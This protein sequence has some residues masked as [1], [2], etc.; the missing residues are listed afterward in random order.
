MNIHDKPFF[1][2]CHTKHVGV[3]S[4]FVAL[5]GMNS[6]GA[7]YIVEALYKGARTIVTDKSLVLPSKIAH[8]IERVHAQLIQVPN[9]RKALAEFAARAYDYPAKKLKIIGI[10]GTKGKTSC[11]WLAE[12]IL[13][14]AGLRTAL[15]ST[16][17]NRIDDAL[18]PAQ[19]TTEHADY[20][21]AFLY[22]CVKQ[23]IDVVVMEVAAQALTLSRVHGILFDGII[24]TN[25]SQEH[26]E[27]Y[28]TISD[29][30]LAKKCI[31][32]HAQ[33]TACVCINVD[34]V[35]SRSIN[36][37]SAIQISV[38]NIKCPIRVD[39]VYTNN[40]FGG[41]LFNVRYFD[42]EVSIECPHL[43]GEY[44][45]SNIVLV[46]SLL[47]SM[48]ISWKDIQN[49]I[50]SFQGIP[51][52]IERVPL[53]NGALGVCDYAHNPSSLYAVLSSLRMQ[54]PHLLVIVGAGGMRDKNKRAV[55]GK[56]IA[57]FAEEIFLTAD[58]PRFE[59]VHTIIDDLLC[60]I[61]P[62]MRYKVTIEVD[63][64]RA[65]QKACSRSSSNSIIGLFGKGP[66]QYQII[67]DQKI[68]FN[69]IDILKKSL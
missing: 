18:F 55:M 58:N 41:L 50:H 30:F 26:G 14:T 19:L 67:G 25:F 36:Y 62:T 56:I 1:V 65:I 53:K 27:F 37:A 12:H 8:E 61:H 31:F 47:H 51:G 20:L 9:A 63:R 4:T 48:N 52:R 68:P 35:M 24:W 43:F 57:D 33:P 15:I 17:H 45:M 28:S 11:A 13:Q 23:R 3:G 16:V 64:E 5:P 21:H 44:N 54:T 22:Q 69:E 60:G 46:A 49:G 66:D 39:K 34:D 10:T 59:N 32:E 6:H 2:T 40:I 29:Y 7:S 38:H 42:E